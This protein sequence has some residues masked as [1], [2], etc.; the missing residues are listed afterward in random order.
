MSG[1]LHPKEM[2]TV[3]ALS[4]QERYSYFFKRVFDREEVWGLQNEAGWVLIGFADGDAFCLWPHGDYARACMIGDWS[5]CVP[6]SISLEELLGELLPALLRD[7]L[8]LAVFPVP[9]GEAVVVDP[10]DFQEHLKSTFE[11]FRSHDT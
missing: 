10:R 6:E 7:N 3:L 5:D 11:H 8:R 1:P 4:G 2:E 9:A